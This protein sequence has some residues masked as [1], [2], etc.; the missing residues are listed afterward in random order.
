[1]LYF[2]GHSS[3]KGGGILVLKG[4]V[5]VSLFFCSMLRRNIILLYGLH[6]QLKIYIYP[7]FLELKLFCVS[8]FSP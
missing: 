3:A 2:Y 4:T 1:M 8:H 7:I 5:L 6:Q